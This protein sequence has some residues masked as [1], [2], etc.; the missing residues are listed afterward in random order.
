MFNTL[1]PYN[2]LDE[3]GPSTPVHVTGLDIPPGA[4]QHFYAV[5]DISLARE[6]STQHQVRNRE[7]SLGGKGPSHVTLENLMDRLGK[8]QAKNLNIILRA[9]TRGSIEAILKELTKLDHPEVKV[10]V[11]QAS[12]GGIS[13]AD[14]H[15]GDA[16]DAVVIGFNV[17]PDEKARSLADQ[18]NVQVRRYDIIYKL[19]ADLKA[20]LEGLLKPEEREMELGRALVS[21]HLYDQPNRYDRRLPSSVRNY[22]TQFTIAGH[23]R[24]PRHW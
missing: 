20:A 15:L 3:A 8:E 14:I 22:S 23:S 19:T 9:D 21:T 6:I 4:G 13:E 1:A 10:K 12:V 5:K 11:L 7:M 18:R 2:K 16:S 24:Q 17:V